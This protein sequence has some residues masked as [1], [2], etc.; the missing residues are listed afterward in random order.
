MAQ[1][2]KL[3]TYFHLAYILSLFNKIAKNPYYLPPKLLKNEAAKQGPAFGV[4]PVF[5]PDQPYPSILFV[6]YQIPI[7]S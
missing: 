5:M 1:S 7:I 2:T 4:I 6:F 3:A